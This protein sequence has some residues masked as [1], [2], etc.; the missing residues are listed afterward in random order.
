MNASASEEAFIAPHLPCCGLSDCWEENV[1]IPQ[2]LMRHENAWPL[3]GGAIIDQLFHL[4][5]ILAH[6]ASPCLPNMPLP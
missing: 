3:V 5:D 2:N 4:I 1:V 6:E